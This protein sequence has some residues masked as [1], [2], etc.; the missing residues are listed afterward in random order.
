VS[1]LEKLFLVLDERQE[2]ALLFVIADAHEEEGREF[3]TGWRWLASHG[4]KPYSTGQGWL[5]ADGLQNEGLLAL[6][7]ILP[8][9]LFE[10]ARSIVRRYGGK[11]SASGAHLVFARAS[12][13]CKCLAEAVA[14]AG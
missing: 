9:D 8:T 7:W 6:C 13:A 14:R 10:K 1:E 2:D 4:K 3:A 5:W 11:L 12:D